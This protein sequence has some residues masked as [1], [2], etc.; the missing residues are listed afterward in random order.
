MNSNICRHALINIYDD[1]CITS[2]Q[3]LQGLVTPM[4][5]WVNARKFVASSKY[6]V[7]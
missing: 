6:T 7:N 5:A 4:C 2:L 1:D 3:T